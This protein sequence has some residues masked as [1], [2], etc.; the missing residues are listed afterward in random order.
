MYQLRLVQASRSE[1][2]VMTVLLPLV[3]GDAADYRR[4]LW[5]PIAKIC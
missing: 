1:I 4:R 2:C 5:L 3:A